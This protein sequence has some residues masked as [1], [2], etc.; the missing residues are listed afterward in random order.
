MHAGIIHPDPDAERFV[1]E[2]ECRFRSGL[3][4][5]T[6]YN[7]IKDGR[8][9]PSRPIPGTARAKAWL[10]SELVAWMRGEWSNDD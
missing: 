4:R 5:I 1:K 7:M 3:G 6:R 9:P 8:F 2:E 10:E